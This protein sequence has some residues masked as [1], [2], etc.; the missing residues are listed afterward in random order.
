MGRKELVEASNEISYFLVF[1][2]SVEN[3]VAFLLCYFPFFSVFFFFYLEYSE[4]EYNGYM[5]Y[6]PT[7]SLVYAFKGLEGN[8]APQMNLQISFVGMQ[9]PILHYIFM[10]SMFML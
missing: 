5:R 10:I 1:L 9:P 3:K 2:S 7:I 6:E 4:V 8:L